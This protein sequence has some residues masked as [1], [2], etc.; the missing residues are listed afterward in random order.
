[1]L[2]GLPL[3]LYKSHYQGGNPLEKSN[4]KTKQKEKTSRIWK[5]CKDQ[6]LNRLQPANIAME[7]VGRQQW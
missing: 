5:F 4:K 6:S 1:M 7:G 3:P 2:S